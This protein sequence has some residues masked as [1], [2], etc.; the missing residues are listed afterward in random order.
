MQA[1]SKIPA[2]LHNVALNLNWFDLSLLTECK[3]F[4]KNMKLKND[5]KDPKERLNRDCSYLKHLIEIRLRWY[6]TERDQ[7]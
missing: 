1:V 3:I 4:L 2:K 5:G 6:D 7:S